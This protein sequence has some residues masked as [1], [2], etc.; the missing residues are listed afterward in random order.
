MPTACPPPVPPA[1]LRVVF[2]VLESLLTPEDNP[3]VCMP[4]PQIQS[5]RELKTAHRQSS[6]T[7]SSHQI[8][9]HKPDRLWSSWAPATGYGA[10]SGH[11][12]PKPPRCLRLP[13]A[14]LL[15]PALLTSIP[16][17]HLPP[18]VLPPQAAR[19]YDARDTGQGLPYK[20]HCLLTRFPTKTV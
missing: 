9:M 16:S 3:H 8:N 18:Q 15:V 14:T 19:H 5:F 13:T 6:N 2:L 4:N 11:K 10:G 20:S 17:L 12:T 1:Q 7:W